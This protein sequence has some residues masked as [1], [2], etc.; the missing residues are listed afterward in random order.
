ML[1][2][3]AIKAAPVLKL[4]L[5]GSYFDNRFIYRQS[6][7]WNFRRSFTFDNVVQLLHVFI[8]KDKCAIN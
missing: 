7:C 2:I 4:Y 8:Y 6:P 5:L 3:V 1:V